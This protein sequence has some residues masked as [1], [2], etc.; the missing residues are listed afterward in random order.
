MK[1]DMQSFSPV[2]AVTI[3]PRRSRPGT[4]PETANEIGS[5]VSSAFQARF[6][7][8]MMPYEHVRDLMSLEAV[9]IENVLGVLAKTS[10]REVE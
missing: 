3:E 8:K 10:R 4:T 7:G 1:N 2:D 9:I 5:A 6:T